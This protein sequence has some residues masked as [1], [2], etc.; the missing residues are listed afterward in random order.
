LQGEA[1]ADLDDVVGD[2][3]KADPALH[4]FETSIAAAIHS[5]APLQ[6]ANAT[7][8]SGPPALSGAKPTRFLQFSPLAAFAV[9]TRHC[10]SPHSHSL[11]GLLIF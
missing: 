8:A 3:A 11:D 2:N 5:M 9:G 7:F 4:A 10:D 1:A 6:H